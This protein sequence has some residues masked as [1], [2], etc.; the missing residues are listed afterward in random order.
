MLLLFVTEVHESIVGKQVRAK[1]RELVED[2]A[3]GDGLRHVVTVQILVTE[4]LR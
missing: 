3:Q 4:Y 1:R 2:I